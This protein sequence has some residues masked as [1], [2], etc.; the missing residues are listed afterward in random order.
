MNKSFINATVIAA[1]AL[2]LTACIKND[3]PYPRIQPNFT[4]FTVE[5]Q[6]QTPLI[7]DQTRTLTVYLSES[8][9]PYAVTVT[10]Y[11]IDPEDAMVVDDA[12]KGTVDLSTPSVVTLRLYQ[13]YDWTIRAI[14]DIERYFTIDGQVG[15]STIDAVNH[16]VIAY[17]PDTQPLDNVTVTSIKLE[18]EGAV[19]E[20]D[21][22]GSKVDFTDPVVVKVT[23]WGRTT[24][25]TLIVEPTEATVTTVSADA[26]SRVVWVYGAAREGK[27]NGFEY[28]QQGASSWTKVP[29]DWI[30]YNGGDFRACISHLEPVTSYEVR[31]YSGEDFGAVITVTTGTEPQLPNSS[32]DSWWLDGKIWCPWAEGTEPFWG[33]GNKGATTLGPSN[34]VPTTETSTGTGQAAMLQTKFVGIGML[35]KLA[36]GNIFAGTY[37]RTEGTNGVLDF[38][39]PFTQRPTRLRGHLK[40]KTAPISSASGDFAALKGEP[41]TCIVWIALT[42]AQTPFEIRT[43]PNNRHLFDRNAADVIAYGEFT[44]GASIPD[45][46][47]FEI[48]LEY[49]ATDRIPNYILVTAS[50]S[51]Y[52]DYFVGADG[53]TLYVDDFELLY[54]Y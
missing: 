5:G 46:I 38:G 37:V 26:W 33:T 24:E 10:D 23:K 30:E 2:A 19:M 36:A 35:G 3:I 6:V 50:A 12:L 4:S 17:L 15:T 52:G 48:P 13:D 20:P 54:D 40:Y 21:I 31:A 51:K 29:S 9:D 16:R 45:Y 43:N 53:A 8:V 44:S 42:D 22:T 27:D 28:R 41:D 7:D 49:N 32:F 25:W 39:R 1:A 47:E 14:Q 34:T 11:A 18:A